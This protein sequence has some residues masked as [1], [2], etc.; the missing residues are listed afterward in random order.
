MFNGN[1]IIFL[2]LDILKPNKNEKK[3][4]SRKCIN[5]LYLMGNLIRK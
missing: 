2:I 1:F 5:L 4:E 3:K